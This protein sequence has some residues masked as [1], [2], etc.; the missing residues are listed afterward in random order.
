P[1]ESSQYP[2]PLLQDHEGQW[3]VAGDGQPVRVIG[4]APDAVIHL[5]NEQAEGHF[6]LVEVAEPGYAPLAVRGIHPG[7]QQQAGGVDTSHP[8]RVARSLAL[9][10]LGEQAVQR[11][12]LARAGLAL[13]DHVPQL[14][15]LGEDVEAVLI[16]ADGDRAG[17][18][19]VLELVDLGERVFGEQGDDRPLTVATGFNAE[20]VAA[21]V[22]G[23]PVRGVPNVL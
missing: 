12:R 11:G 14:V 15:D 21:E 17:H 18:G 20:P 16:P 2:R 23:Q 5:V 13:A 7:P 9:G 8:D 22:R 19:A 10:N 1:V 3:V 6:D 4:D